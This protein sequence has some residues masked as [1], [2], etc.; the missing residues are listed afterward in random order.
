MKSPSSVRL[1][2]VA[3]QI[4]SYLSTHKDAQD[5]IEGIAEWWLLEQRVHHMIGEVKKAL[6]ELVAQRMVVER[7]GRDGRA[8][9]RLNPRKQRRVAHVLKEA[10]SDSYGTPFEPSTGKAPLQK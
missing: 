4:L 3:L 2:S 6:A 9:Y 1:G 5:T 10:S 8:H 7:T